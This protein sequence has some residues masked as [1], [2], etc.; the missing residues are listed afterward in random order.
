MGYDEV[1]LAKYFGISILPFF[2]SLGQ[3]FLP[4]HPIPGFLNET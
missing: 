1:Y 3:C 2:P 4:Y